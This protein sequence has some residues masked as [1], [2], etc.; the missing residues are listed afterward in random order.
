MIRGN[1]AVI[2]VSIMLLALASASQPALAQKRPPREAG[3]TSPWARLFGNWDMTFTDKNGSPVAKGYFA[4]HDTP[5]TTSGATAGIFTEKTFASSDLRCDGGRVDG[6]KIELECPYHPIPF[7]DLRLSPDGSTLRGTWA[8][9]RNAPAKGQVVWTRSRP[10]IIERVEVIGDDESALDQSKME[11]L[12]ADRK[13]P[14]IRLRV[15]GRELPNWV[16]RYASPKREYAIDDPDYEIVSERVSADGYKARWARGVVEIV[17]ALNPGARPGRKTV[18][19]NGAQTSFDV[20]FKNYREP[21]RVVELKFIR[22][23]GTPLGDEVRYGEEF[24]VEARFNAPPPDAQPVVKLEWGGGARDVPVFK[25]K[26]ATVFRSAPLTVGAPT[27][28]SGQR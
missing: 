20:A 23:D 13:R 19:V 5:D 6:L 14:R 9:R 7:M 11:K 8:S 24:Y 18:T 28:A 25:Q 1:R 17:A 26:D 22:K 2:A 27:E 21:S 16:G 15:Y 4:F 3:T 12:W 10:P